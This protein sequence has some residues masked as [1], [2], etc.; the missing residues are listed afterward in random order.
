MSSVNFGDIIKPICYAA[1]AARVALDTAHSALF[2][3]LDSQN[4][5]TLP[6][7]IE[8]IAIAYRIAIRLIGA[9]S[10]VGS[11]IRNEADLLNG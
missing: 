4:I 2:V 5:I 8:S 6:D 9:E 7:N 3:A 10:P 1:V 11:K